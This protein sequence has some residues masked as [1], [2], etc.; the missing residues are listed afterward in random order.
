MDLDTAPSD[1]RTLRGL[2]YRESALASDEVLALPP[3][4]AVCL[5]R[6]RQST[7]ASIDG[8]TWSSESAQDAVRRHAESVRFRK[9]P[10]ISQGHN[11]EHAIAQDQSRVQYGDT[12]N[13]NSCDSKCHH[14]ISTLLE[15]FQSQQI[16]FADLQ[17]Q[18]IDLMKYVQNTIPSSITGRI[19]VL[20]DAHGRSWRID[21]DTIS[22]WKEF[23]SLLYHKFEND[24]GLRRIQDSKYLLRN[25]DNTTQINPT[26]RPGFMSVFK[27]G[28]SIQMSVYFSWEEVRHHGCPKCASEQQSLPG[29]E[30]ICS[31]CD[32]TYTPGLNETFEIKRPQVNMRTT[33]ELFLPRPVLS[34]DVEKLS[35]HA[36]VDLPEY[37]KRVS[38]GAEI[39]LKDDSYILDDVRSSNY[40]NNPDSLPISNEEGAG[41]HHS[42][43]DQADVDMANSASHLES[44]SPSG[45]QLPR[46]S[47]H[48]PSNYSDQPNF[49]LNLGEP[50]RSR[51]DGRVQKHAANF[52]CHL[53]PKCFTRAYNLR[54]HLRTHTDERPLVCT[55]CGKAFAR[56]HDRKRH[57]GLHNGEKKYICKGTLE[58]STRWGCGRRFARA[59]ALGAHLR[60]EVGRVCIKPVLDEEAA[61]A[62]E[63]AWPEDRAQQ[64]MAADINQFS[65]NIS[66]PPAQV[67]VLPKLIQPSTSRQPG[68]SF[69]SPKSDAP[70][71]SLASLD[72]QQK[73]HRGLA[74]EQS[75]S[76]LDSFIPD[77]SIIA[78]LERSKDSFI[79][80]TQTYDPTPPHLLQDMP[81]SPTPPHLLPDMP[82]R[83]S[84]SPRPQTTQSPLFG[85]PQ[86][87]QSLP[88]PPSAANMV[89]T[90]DGTFP[91]SRPRELDLPSR[92]HPTRNTR[93][94][95]TKAQV[96]A[97]IEAG[98]GFTYGSPPNPSDFFDSQE[99][100]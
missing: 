21:I 23:D 78:D 6:K 54:S 49:I 80:A 68:Q 82:R 95:L 13:I 65:G 31:T 25:S 50:E 90:P 73:T 72:Q 64:Q 40:F 84:Q 93:L 10:Q 53:C 2:G 57:E 75:D 1:A 62:R 20:E 92:E 15:Q 45:S 42:H 29:V 86:F 79:E 59:D 5:K 47:R 43:E 85:D 76:L 12:Y 16:Q 7:V 19:S 37:F 55:I 27:P 33:M 35:S 61:A 3:S 88:S 34:S 77:G 98:V 63:K 30:T 14:L 51:G 44:G 58:S 71:V 97:N 91:Y 38:V 41:I 66:Y 28:Q 56:Q 94:R 74:E 70:S 67:S 26:R 100:E 96:E 32:F 4:Q 81:Y 48:R 99:E 24:R 9:R 18:L 87:S 17:K 39:P 83:R 22:G 89:V 52:Q 60:S 46:S 69:A 11:F 8:A 36:E